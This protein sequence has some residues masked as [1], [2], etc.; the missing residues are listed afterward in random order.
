MQLN[1]TAQSKSGIENY[2]FLSSKEA[3][4]WMPLV[5]HV[6]KKAVYTELRYNYEAVGAA[7]LYMGKS[8]TKKSTTAYTLT[9]MLGLVMGSYNGGSLAL[10]AELEHKKTFASMQTQ[11]TVSSDAVKDN[12]FFTWT[13]IGYQ[14]FKWLYAGVSTQQT[15]QYGG[16]VQSE[17]GILTGFVVK[18]ITV[19]VYVFNPLNKSRNFIIGI[20]T[21]W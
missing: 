13:E 6:S 14:P 7:S 16:E 18:K 3:Y 1:A 19:P 8:F 12:F 10:N 11:Y 21:E 17:Y 4:V 20:N 2:N 5:H 15:I 9:P